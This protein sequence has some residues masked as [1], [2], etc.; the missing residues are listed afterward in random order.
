MAADMHF[1]HVEYGDVEI[2]EGLFADVDIAAEFTG[3]GSADPAGIG[4]VT[5]QLAAQS[6]SQGLVAGRRGVELGQQRLTTDPVVRYLLAL[7]VEG[8]P[9]QNL[10]PVAAMFTSTRCK[11]GQYT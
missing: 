7:A 2:E 5:E 10:V 9:R 3:E 4:A 1:T 6:L 11:R 8:A